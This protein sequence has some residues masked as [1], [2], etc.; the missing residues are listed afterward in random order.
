MCLPF[1]VKLAATL[2]AHLCDLSRLTILAQCAFPLFQQAMAFLNKTGN[3]RRAAHGRFINSRAAP[4]RMRRD[5]Q[6]D[7][8]FNY[9]RLTI[10]DL[11][12]PEFQLSAFRLLAFQRFSVLAFQLSTFSF[13]LSALHLKPNTFQLKTS[14]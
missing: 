12:T 2:F 5:P 9:S 13:Q 6:S 8:R 11:T 7:A 4:Q 3:C 10:N 14:N 1:V